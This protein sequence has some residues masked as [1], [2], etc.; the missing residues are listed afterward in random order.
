MHIRNFANWNKLITQYRS[1]V[2]ST[3]LI[4]LPDSGAMPVHMNPT[5]LRVTGC[6]LVAIPHRNGHGA[7]W[8]ISFETLCN[9]PA[10]K[11]PRIYRHHGLICRSAF[12][13][14][15]P[16]H[17]HAANQVRRPQPMNSG[18]RQATGRGRG[19]AALA[20][21]SPTL[22]TV[23]GCCLSPRNPALGIVKWF[24]LSVTAMF[25]RNA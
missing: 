4:Y 1:L 23:C 19:G 14:G 21:I 10:P 18:H 24:N 11:V 17:I 15:R 7:E 20:P 16:G 13:D 9:S 8:R 25:F 5:N 12:R 6:L 2:Q 22:P 3:S